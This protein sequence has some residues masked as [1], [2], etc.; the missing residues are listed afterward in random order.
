AENGKDQVA[1]LGDDLF[2]GHRIFRSA[3]DI[4][5]AASEASAVLQ[6]DVQH[7]DTQGHEP[8]EVVVRDQLDF[9][10]L[11]Q[12]NRIF[13]TRGVVGQSEGDGLIQQRDGEHV[14]SADVGNFAIVDDG[15][16][17][18]GEPKSHLLYLSD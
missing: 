1:G 15:G 3:A 5:D 6:S 17:I 11:A 8:L 10:A 9:G 13:H 12:N 18:G 7:C 16:F 2:A 14:L 4:T